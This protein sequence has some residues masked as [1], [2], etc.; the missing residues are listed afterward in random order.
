MFKNDKDA[1]IVEGFR[2]PFIKSGLDFNNISEEELGTWLLREL[3]ERTQIDLN[4]VEKVILANVNNSTNNPNIAHTIALRA[5]LPRSISATTVQKMDISSI[6]SLVTATIKIN[7]GFS[8][9]VIA[10]GVESMSQMPILLHYRMSQIIKKIIQAKSW[11]EKIKKVMDLR[12]SYIKPQFTNKNILIDPVSGWSQI[13][14]AEKLS[15]D[16]HISRE[17]QDEFALDSFKKASLAQKNEKWKEDIVPIFPPDDFGLVDK[18]TKME[19]TLSMHNFSELQPYFEKDYG[20]V[21][22]GNSSFAADG[23]V[24]FLVM[25]REKAKA[26]GYKPL[27]TIH[28]SAHSG[29][30]CQQHGLGSIY[31]IANILKKEKLQIKDIDLFEIGENFAAQTLACLKIFESPI[32]AEKYLKQTP[33]KIDPEKCNVN[34]GALALGNPISVTDARMVLSV[35]KE[36]NRQQKEWG[37][38]ATGMCSGQASALLLRNNLD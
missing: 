33:E 25:S 26:L 11:K 22:S 12:L 13:Q 31:A 38:V 24:L 30:E 28:S 32:L 4:E 16:F 17:E 9:I 19:E 2:T 35:A 18:D 6:A 7:T 37:L 14:I 27:V 29:M 34:G 20:T 10:G 36:M 1:V 5:G 3:L 21:T 23:A 8:N 15:E